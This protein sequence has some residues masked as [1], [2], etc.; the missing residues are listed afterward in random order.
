M[1][2]ETN[3]VNMRGYAME[4]ITEVRSLD[5]ILFEVLKEEKEMLSNSMLFSG[6]IRGKLMELIRDDQFTLLRKKVDEYGI[7]K[8]GGIKLITSIDHST[9]SA[10]KDLLDIGV[11]VKHLSDLLTTEFVVSDKAVIEIISDQ[12]K[13]EMLIKTDPKVVQDHLNKF[14]HIWKSGIDA[15]KRVSELTANDS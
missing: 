13:G 14:E 7:G 9:V 6:C 8:H 5:P 11:E 12:L 1:T 3:E 15:G 4:V 10:V 2:Q